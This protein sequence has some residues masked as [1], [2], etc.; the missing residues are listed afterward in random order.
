M[1]H[2]LF[3]TIWFVLATTNSVLAAETA[4]AIYYNGN[5]LT[6]DDEQP[7]AEA[8]AVKDGR[9]L[10]VGPKE[11]V[12][13]RAGV[14]TKKM[15][16]GGKTMLPGFI[17]SHSH[18]IL[19]AIKQSTVNMD[20]P[21]AGDVSSI[22][23]IKERF[24]ARLAE[25]PKDSRGWILGWGYDNGMLKEG[26]HPTRD[27][28]D[29]VSRD[30]PILLLHFSTHQVVANSSALDASGISAESVNPE[31]GVIRRRQGSR[32]PNGIIEETAMLPVLAA[33]SKSLQQGTEGQ[34]AG[35]GQMKF[36]IG[37]PSEEQMMELIEA[38]IQT[39]AS[40]GFTTVSEF[41]GSLDQAEILRKMGDQG[42]LPVDVAM[43]IIYLGST[44]DQVAAASSSTYKNHFRVIGGKVNLDGG[45]PGRTAFLREPYYNQ[46]P[47]ETGYRGYSS[48]EKQK[49]L[50]ALVA[51]YYETNTPIF[52]HALGDA[53]VDQ[54]IAAVSHAEKLY[55]GEGRRTQLI[56]L[57]QVQE[58]QFDAL[59][60]LDVTLTFQVAHNYYF[61]DFHAKEIYGPERT[62]RLNPAASALK[63]NFSVTIHHDSP[64]HPI[65][66]FMLIWNSVERKSRSGKVW[67]EDQRISVMDALKASTINAAY[68]YHEE[69]TKGSI[70]VG[71]LAD[72]VIID[73]NPLEI[74]TAELRELKV[75][76]TIKEGR[77]V[78]TRK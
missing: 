65:D 23:D 17:D 28:L 39:Y 5:I 45:S 54:C 55:P 43:A 62:A 58:D 27:D 16:L 57:Q 63:R 26:R 13:K 2:I 25:R 34:D 44:P 24:A 1:K 77:T 68:Q 11:D 42:R 71:K 51:S 12:F 33:Y 30:V 22:E 15:D 41:G 61:A 14:E 9:I 36:S 32:E 52:I 40:K 3:L 10:A 37:P 7:T 59:Q 67:G 76:E 56:H 70:E 21:P 78:Y 64:V 72:L 20:P 38:S 29:E 46:Y 48:I 53:A 60:K 18:L 69:N 50:N 35:M 49:D 4:D 75:L 47:G 66:Q 73:R 8:V 19:S 74:A 31:G 6:M